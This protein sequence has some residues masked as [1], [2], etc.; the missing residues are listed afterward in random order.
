MSD[1]I[2]SLKGRNGK[3]ELYEDY[4]RIDRGTAMGF[5]LQGLK[6]QKDIYIDSITSI[7]VKKPGLMVGYIQFSLAGG[8]ESRRGAFNANK[9]ENTV[10]FSGKD[11]YDE[12]LQ[13]K[14]YI[15]NRRRKESAH[16]DRGSLADELSKLV[17]LKDEGAITSEEYESLK[18]KLL[19][20]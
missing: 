1:P 18:R 5:L 14:A 17:A 8:I 20:S 6:G 10:T 4:V 16:Q 13:V 19:S 15:E 12:A 7:Q 2:V 9:D 11:R 3:L